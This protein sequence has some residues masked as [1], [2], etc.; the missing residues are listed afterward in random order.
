MAVNRCP[1]VPYISSNILFSLDLYSHFGFGPR[2]LPL[3]DDFTVYAGISNFRIPDRNSHGSLQ[4]T[5][6]QIESDI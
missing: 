1:S 6:A 5:H 3:G 2:C 4:L